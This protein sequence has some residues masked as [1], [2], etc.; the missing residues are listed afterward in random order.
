MNSRGPII[1]RF[2]MSYIR[3]VLLF[4]SSRVVHNRGADAIGQYDIY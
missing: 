3:D 1:V 2:E 4:C